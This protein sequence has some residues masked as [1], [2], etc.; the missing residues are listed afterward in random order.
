MIKNGQSYW[1]SLFFDKKR[2][3][4]RKQGR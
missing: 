2:E 4:D 3:R 1:V